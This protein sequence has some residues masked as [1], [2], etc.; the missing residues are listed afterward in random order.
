MVP[1]TIEIVG[2]V[3]VPIC[4]AV[5]GYFVKALHTQI[6]EQADS[7]NQRFSEL[8]ADMKQ[9]QRKDDTVRE[10]GRVDRD[11]DRMQTDI[12]KL[13]NILRAQMAEDKRE[14]LDAINRIKQ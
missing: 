1:G 4:L 5:I 3:V 11:L 9:T 7:A 14:L 10:F 12:D 8:T 13:I 2:M 6:K